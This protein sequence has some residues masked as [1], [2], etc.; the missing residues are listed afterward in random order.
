MALRQVLTFFNFSATEGKGDNFSNS[1][2]PTMMLGHV[3]QVKES[4]R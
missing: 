1:G 3:Q 4:T 2:V